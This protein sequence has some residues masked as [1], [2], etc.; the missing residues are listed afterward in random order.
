MNGTLA[1]S[2]AEAADRSCPGQIAAGLY[3]ASILGR[4]AA[5]KEMFSSRR[6]R[7]GNSCRR[8]GEPLAVV[9]DS[10]AVASAALAFTRRVSILGSRLYQKANLTATTASC[11]G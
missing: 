9:A 7:R 4:A 11:R 5:S 10:I 2:L 8:C 6:F 3:L 1:K